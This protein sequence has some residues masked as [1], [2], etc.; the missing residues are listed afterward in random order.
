[1]KAHRPS[2]RKEVCLALTARKE[3]TDVSWFSKEVGNPQRE[4]LS[5][6]FNP[7]DKG[8]VGGPFGR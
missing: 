6:S 2:F 7:S 1:M 5:L 8:I 4:A 3:V